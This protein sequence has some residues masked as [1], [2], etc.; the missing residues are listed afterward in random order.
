[1][2]ISEALEKYRLSLEQPKATSGPNSPHGEQIE[3]IML[4]MGEDPKNSTRYAYWCG[5]TKYWTPETIYLKLQQAQKGRNPQ[6]LFNYFIKD[7]WQKTK[8]LSVPQ[9]RAKSSKPSKT[10]STD[11]MTSSKQ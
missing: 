5:K 7:L 4:F 3:A 10:I 11:S 1:M 6:A 9:N 2:H 8:F